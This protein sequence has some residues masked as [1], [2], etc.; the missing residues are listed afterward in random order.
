[1]SVCA[2]PRC[3]RKAKLH[4]SVP[5]YQQVVCLRHIRWGLAIV[6]DWPITIHPTG[7]LTDAELRAHGQVTTYSNVITAADLV[8]L[9]DMGVGRSPQETKP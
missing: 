9:D 2:A 3:R 6:A 4:L 7:H 5:S 1:M 8:T